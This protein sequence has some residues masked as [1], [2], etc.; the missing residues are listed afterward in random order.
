MKTRS[1]TGIKI[2]CLML[3]CTFISAGNQINAQSAIGQLEHMTGVRIDRGNTSSS[4]NTNTTSSYSASYYRRLEKASNYNESAIRFMNSGDYSKAIR[5]LKK[6]QWYDP[7]NTTVKSNLAKARAAN[8]RSH[9]IPVYKPVKPTPP[10]ASNHTTNN[11]TTSR[12][13]PFPGSGN[14]TQGTG[15]TPNGSVPTNNNLT[16]TTLDGKTRSLKLCYDYNYMAEMI[17]EKGIEATQ[18]E[19]VDIGE[20]LEFKKIMSRNSE[21]SDLPNGKLPAA[22]GAFMLNITRYSISSVENAANDFVAGKLTNVDLQNLN[23]NVII[24]KAVLTTLE[25]AVTD[26]A[27]SAYKKLG[28]AYL[29]NRFGEISEVFSEL[30]IDKAVKVKDMHETYTSPSLLFSKPKK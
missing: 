14:T 30:A 25:D 17:P 13:R 4:Y 18:S 19:R 29:D 27:Q 16:I 20:T 6:A 21:I 7:F 15:T 5:M 23:V 2:L 10:V 24:N 1:Q 3:L 22:I 9:D 28:I 11:N 12:P 8:D 26:L